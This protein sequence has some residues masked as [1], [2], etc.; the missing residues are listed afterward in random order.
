MAEI[1][2]E[3]SGGTKAGTK[4]DATGKLDV[5]ATEEVGTKLNVTAK[6]TVDGKELTGTAVATVTAP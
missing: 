6:T 1:T 4:I 5:D 3:V 2:W